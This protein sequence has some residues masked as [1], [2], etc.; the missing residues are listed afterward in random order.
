V[1]SVQGQ[2]EEYELTLPLQ[3]AQVKLNCTDT[4]NPE[5]IGN[6]VISSDGLC[7]TVD[8]KTM[9]GVK[10]KV[11]HSIDL[12]AFAKAP[13]KT[14]TTYTFVPENGKIDKITYTAYDNA[15]TP[16]VITS[17]DLEN[18]EVKK[19]IATSYSGPLFGTFPGLSI[20]LQDTWIDTIEKTFE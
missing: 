7:W 8:L 19:A 14:L 1:T 13:G 5:N 17:R 4:E 3:V 2:P 15:T 10:G 9:N 18:V 16:Q 6:V 11:S 12:S 20:T